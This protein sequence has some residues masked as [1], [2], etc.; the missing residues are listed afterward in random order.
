MNKIYLERY[1]DTGFESQYQSQHLKDN[2]YLLMSDED[3]INLLKEDIPP[4]CYNDE[5]YI[6]QLLRGK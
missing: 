1:S 2:E 5:I 4:N 6:G 3:Y